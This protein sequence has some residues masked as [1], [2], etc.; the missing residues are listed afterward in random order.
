RPML[1]MRKGLNFLD[2]SVYPRK[3]YCSNLP[4]SAQL[5]P[6]LRCNLK[7]TMCVREHFKQGDMK[8]E[9]FKR[10][11]N[12]LDTLVKIHL[13]GLGEPFL[14]PDIFEMIDYASSRNIMVSVITNGTLLND[15]FVDK[16]S[17]SKLFEIGISI[18][19]TE[20]KEYEAIRVGANFG[21]VIGGVKKLSAALKGKDTKLFFAVTVMRSNLHML[22]DFVRLAHNV[23]VPR[24]V[25]QR[26][27]TKDDFVSY[28]KSDF[29]KSGD[30]VTHE[31]V[32]SVFDSAR[33]LADSLC[34][35]ILFEEKT[36]KCLWPWRSLYITWNGDITPCCMIVDPKSPPIGNILKTPFKVLWNSKVYRVLRKSLLKRTPIA[37]CK[38]CR[39]I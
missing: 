26:V 39:A 30:F 9:E 29:R 28:Y 14:H 15:S 34:V 32:K 21:R 37:P 11:I 13:Q 12:Q 6:T 35:E 31:E 23:G 1:L 4:I 20:K 19:A 7:C 38:G 3:T 33:S 24:V 25:F 18:D 17:K 8:L 10:I 5:E 22:P 27:Q 16:I 36:V 2:Y